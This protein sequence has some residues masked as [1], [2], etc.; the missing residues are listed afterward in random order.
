[1]AAAHI[2]SEGASAHGVEPSTS[3]FCR[4]QS[5]R[6]LLGD[7]VPTDTQ[8]DRDGGLDRDPGAAAAQLKRLGEVV[9]YWRIS[10]SAGA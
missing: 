10:W 1:M 2:G 8:H 4:P 5:R 3:F 7:G 9:G 6:L